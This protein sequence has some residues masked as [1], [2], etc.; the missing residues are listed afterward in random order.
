MLH[1]FSI[2]CAAWEDGMSQIDM[3]HHDI[4]NRYCIILL[5]VKS[6]EIDTF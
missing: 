1:N 4:I 6:N 2:I 5:K 3:L